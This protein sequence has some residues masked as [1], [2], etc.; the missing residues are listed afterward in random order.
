MAGREEEAGR[1][2]R[3]KVP[4]SLLVLG[5][6]PGGEGGDGRGVQ[7]RFSVPACDRRAERG[8]QILRGTAESPRGPTGNGGRGLVGTVYLCVTHSPT[9]WPEGFSGIW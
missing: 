2:G 3:V 5:N 6:D 7:L 1:V 4:G 9:P 8:L